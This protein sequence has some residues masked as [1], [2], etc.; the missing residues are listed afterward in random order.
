MRIWVRQEFCRWIKDFSGWFGLVENLEHCLFHNGFLIFPKLSIYVHIVS[1]VLKQDR[2]FLCVCKIWKVVNAIIANLK[3]LFEN[4]RTYNPIR[5]GRIFTKLT[6]IF[7][8]LLWYLEINC[9]KYFGHFLFIDVHTYKNYVNWYE[10][11]PVRIISGMLDGVC[12]FV[13]EN[14][15]ILFFMSICCWLLKKSTNSLMGCKKRIKN[16]NLIILVIFFQDLIFKDHKM[17]NNQRKKY[18]LLIITTGC[19]NVHPWISTWW[20]LKL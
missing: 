16:K 18:L 19:R 7:T 9:Q 5:L 17:K 2:L 13:L 8:F 6:D 3:I 10:C 11:S 15:F 4:H 20:G 1:K 14:W 12:G